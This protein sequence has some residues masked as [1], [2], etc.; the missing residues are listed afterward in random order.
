MNGRAERLRLLIE[1][2][3]A[4]WKKDVVEKAATYPRSETLDEYVTIDPNPEAPEVQISR[5][6]DGWEPLEIVRGMEAQFTLRSVALT[7]KVADLFAV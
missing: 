3:S 6:A 1:V 5:R 2:L 4:D 7:L